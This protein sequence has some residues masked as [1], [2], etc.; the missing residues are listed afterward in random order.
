M[1]K[2]VEITYGSSRLN[3]LY[4]NTEEEVGAIIA[5]TNAKVEQRQYKDKHG[6]RHQI[7]VS[8]SGIHERYYDWLGLTIFDPVRGIFRSSFLH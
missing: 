2:C 4:V 3:P 6:G 5:L 7:D 8:Y 1:M